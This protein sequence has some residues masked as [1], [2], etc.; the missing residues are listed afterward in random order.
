MARTK[1]R[2]VITSNPKAKLEVAAKIYEKHLAMG[3]KS[4]L[5]VLADVDW[6]VTGPNVAPALEAHNKAEF[7]KGEMEKEYA[8]RDTR[9][10]EIAKAL[11][12][13]INLLKA[14][15]GENPKKLADWGVNVDDSPK[16]KSVKNTKSQ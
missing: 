7:H 8:N 2:V 6:A 16:V 10:P 12:L 9:M 4:P 14:S 15:F 5:V 1:G 3:S 11:K 13:S